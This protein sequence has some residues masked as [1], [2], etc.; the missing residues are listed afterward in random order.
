MTN[1]PTHNTLKELRR[2]FVTAGIMLGVVMLV[3]WAYVWKT[4]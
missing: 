4:T 2:N 1:K 3:A